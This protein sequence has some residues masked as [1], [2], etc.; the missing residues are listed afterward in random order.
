MFTLQKVGKSYAGRRGVVHALRDVSL[1]IEPGNFVT[2]AGPSGSGKTTLLLTLGG[3]IRPTSGQVEFL[4]TDLGSL[5][6][7]RLAAYRNQSV[8]FVLQSFN[9]IPYLSAH[10][11]VMVPMSLRANGDANHGRRAT[12]LLERLGLADRMDHLPRE[13]SVGQ[14]QRVAMARALGN[15]PEVI[16]AD[17]PTGNLDPALAA[18]ILRILQDLNVQDGRTVIMVTHSPEAA[19]IGTHRVHLDEGRCSAIEGLGV[20]G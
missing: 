15:N 1:T 5:D 9:L 2:V 12:E 6:E 7:R 13:L 20:G 11:N 8:G 10:E 3:L 16:L 4:G 14:Q 18:E 17:E 19:C